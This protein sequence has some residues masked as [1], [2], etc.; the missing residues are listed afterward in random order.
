MWNSKPGERRLREKEVLPIR[1][2]E[3]FPEIIP[4]KILDADLADYW[5]WAAGGE[6]RKETRI[7]KS[8]EASKRWRAEWPRPVEIEHYHRHPALARASTTMMM[9][10]DG[11]FEFCTSR[12]HHHAARVQ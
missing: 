6:H 2:K 12:P 4:I 10:A 11:Q 5:R 9:T 8:C 3:I 7:M 1:E